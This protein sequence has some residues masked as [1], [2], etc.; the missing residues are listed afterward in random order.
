[1]AN[2]GKS[3][4]DVEH[5]RLM[6]RCLVLRYV[7][8]MSAAAISRE[9]LEGQGRSVPQ[10]RVSQ[11]LAGALKA[12]LIKLTPPTYAELEDKVISRF[13]HLRDAVVVEPRRTGKAIDRSEMSDVASAAGPLFQRVLSEVAK[14]KRES[15]SKLKVKVGLSCGRSI[16]YMIEALDADYLD[17]PDLR[18]VEIK[19]YPLNVLSMSV[20][21]AQS[22]NTLV[23]MLN[24]KWDSRK[25][26]AYNFQITEK[27]DGKGSEDTSQPKFEDARE[28]DIIVVGIGAVSPGA[29]NPGFAELIELADC[30]EKLKELN[31]V[32]EINYQP[33]SRAG[34]LG[35]DRIPELYDRLAKAV[36]LAEL[37]QLARGSE[38]Y[39]IAVA[40]GGEAKA[41][42]VS[43]SLRRN[44]ACYNMLVT[45][46]DIARSLI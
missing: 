26:T 24:A 15:G 29:I 32:G 10:K 27:S 43:V 6:W 35:R 3:E 23:G 1:M 34:V 4:Q 31:V 5:R 45:D 30:K 17:Q 12:N 7:K 13:P 37:Q 33:F 40:A 8:G 16:M 9:L 20:S 22:P 14:R 44:I 38:T 19:L 28:A 18:D 36:S 2:S 21:T 46:D 25:V 11:L 41:P 42:A 39:V